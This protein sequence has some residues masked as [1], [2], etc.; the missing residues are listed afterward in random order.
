[1]WRPHPGFQE[2]FLR[3]PE[4]EALAGG[5]AGPGKTDLLI[6]GA[7]RHI[8]HP[9]YHG[10]ILRRTRPRL[11]EILDRC[12]D[13][14]SEFGAE[15]KGISKRFEFPSGA[16]I[17]LGH[18][19]HED[20]KRDYH[21]KE[22]QYIGFDELTEFTQS[23]Y[24]FIA[25]SRSRSTVPGIKIRV[26]SASNPGGKGHAWV[27]E[28]FVDVCKPGRSYTDPVTGLTRVF[29]PGTV[30]D[31]PTLFDNDP[32]YVSRLMGLPELE[33]DRLLYGIWDA[34]EGQA[35]RELS[36]KTHGC[37]PFDIPPEWT[38]FCV[39]DWGYAKPFSVGW[40]ALDYDDVMYR[41]REWYGSTKETHGKEDGANTGT[42][43][44]AWEVAKGI[45]DRENGEK[46]NFRTADTSIFDARPSFRRKESRGVTIAEDF[47]SEGVH[48]NKADRDRVQGRHQVHKRLK[49]DEQIDEDGEV[50]T[51][52]PQFQAFN[53]QPAFWRTM[54]NLVEDEK[55]PEDIDTKQE[56]HA[57]D[58]FRY[59]CMARPVAPKKVVRIQ[60]G[61]IR[62]EIDKL[63]RAKKRARRLGISVAEAYRKR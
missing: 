32:Q 11:Q 8:E 56:D 14:Y 42:R 17:T 49:L 2:G 50:K 6:A 39:L 38:K 29:I 63:K 55:N 40:Y 60:P 4:F 18:C 7:T 57:Y 3:R 44:Q 30:Q 21:G 26:R 9:K 10:L 52:S 45:L 19:Q 59:M 13:V 41:Y 31:N 23:Q 47:S 35:F 53:D 27:K 54:L 5:A 46:I 22:F 15:W 37:E 20:S 62:Y 16:K 33:R 34:F 12:H 48:F 36:T 1:M 43:M 51:E 28:R 61:T 58:E 24:E 25:L